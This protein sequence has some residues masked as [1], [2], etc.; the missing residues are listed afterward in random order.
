MSRRKKKEQAAG[1]AST[2]GGGS[3]KITPVDI[4]QKEFRLAFRGYNERDVDRFLDEVTEEFARLFEENKRLRE[5]MGLQGTTKLEAGEAAEADAIIRSARAEAARIVAEAR[6]RSVGALAP[7]GTVAS[8]PTGRGVVNAF[9]AREREF[10]QSL[11]G[12]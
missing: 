4:Q 3:G 8:D 7:P 2:P 1:F 5:D 6:S 9:L 10:L 12:L 11:A